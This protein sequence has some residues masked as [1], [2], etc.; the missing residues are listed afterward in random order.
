MLRPTYKGRLHAKDKAAANLYLV[1]AL[2]FMSTSGVFMALLH[3]INFDRVRKGLS[4]LGAD[5][6]DPSFLATIPRHEWAMPLMWH[7][8]AFDL[9]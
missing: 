8:L 6:L 2:G 1:P 7:C 5:A 4:P 3:A 9:K